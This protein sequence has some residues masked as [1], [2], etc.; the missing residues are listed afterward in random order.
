[1]RQQHKAHTIGRFGEHIRKSFAT[2][3]LIIVPVVVT[4]AALAFVFEKVDGVLQPGLEVAL[5]RRIPGLGLL[6][7]VV[8]IYAVGLIGN[9]VL[10]R[11]LI[12]GGQR[13]LQR[14]PIAGAVYTSAR[15][16]IDSFS[17]QGSTGFKRVVAFES[18]RPGMWTIGFLTGFTRD[19]LGRSQGIVYVPTA[20][21]PNSGWMSVI[22][23][24]DIYDT[25]LAVAEAMRLI[26][27]GGIV[28][29]ADIRK[30][31]LEGKGLPPDV[32]KNTKA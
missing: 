18:P 30:R 12:A 26:L 29:P 20:P 31:P 14:L 10:G 17:G 5:G 27:S 8:I 23:L 32:I 9:R 3:L 2:G 13:L 16:L 28:A 22:P 24:E 11:K 6:G 4:M 21:M 1:M 15:E 25:D 19:E 7:L